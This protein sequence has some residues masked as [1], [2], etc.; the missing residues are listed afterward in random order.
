[1]PF[2]AKYYELVVSTSLLLKYEEILTERNGSLVGNSVLAVLLT[3]SNVRR[4]R[5]S[6]DFR[7]VEQDPDDDKFV[8]AYVAGQADYLVTDDRH[9]R[10][11]LASK[12]PTVRVVSA[13]EFME[14]LTE[15]L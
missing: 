6:F 1:M 7:L 3:R 10:V 15:K 11:M 4:Q 13:A 5:I 9:F 14:V 12:F 2:L 8:N